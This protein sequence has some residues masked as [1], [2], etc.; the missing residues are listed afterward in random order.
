[1][2]GNNAGIPPGQDKAICHPDITPLS[3]YIFGD[4]RRLE[5]IVGR[6][7]ARCEGDGQKQE[8]H[9]EQR[10]AEER[11]KFEAERAAKL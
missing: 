3:R 9:C 10:E 1:M 8:D 4:L 7:R 2:H 6:E 11:A 5:F